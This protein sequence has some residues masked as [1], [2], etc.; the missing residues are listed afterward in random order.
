MPNVNGVG[1]VG[2]WKRVGYVWVVSPKLSRMV[3]LT[4]F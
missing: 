2:L 1:K 3:N 4:I